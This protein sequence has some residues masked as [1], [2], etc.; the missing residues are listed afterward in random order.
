[1]SSFFSQN[2]IEKIINC[3]YAAGEIAANFQKSGNFE[4][5]KKPDNS[6]VTSAD[7]AVSK[8]ISQKLNEEFPQIPI[9]CEEGKLREAQDIFWLIDPIDGT[10][11]F[12]EG[13]AEFAVNIALIKDGRAI[14]GLIYAPLFEGGKMIFSD[15]ENKIITQNN[16]GEKKTLAFKKSVPNILRI[17][18]SPR[19]KDRD[20][21][22]YI[23]QICRNFEKKFKVERLAS[24]V[25]F[26]R[27]LEND[28][29]L[30]LHFRQSM[31]WDTAAGQALVE[32]INGS[33]KTISV[34]QDKISIGENLAYKKPDFLNQ[35]FITFIN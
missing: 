2:Q 3:A 24:A 21:E 30:Y 15:H 19:T 17:V 31:E 29:D 11:G 1:M 35:S 13:K 10:S 8:F 18:T 14:F 32:L 7:I 6:S 23:E 28:A 25:K 16:A 9:I 4:I 33:V 22:N 5:M 27:I 20:I 12:I 26:F 34:N